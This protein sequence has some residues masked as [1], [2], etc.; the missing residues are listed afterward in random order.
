MIMDEQPTPE[1]QTSPAEQAVPARQSKFTQKRRQVFCRCVR[2]GLDFTHA[3]HVAGIS[4][5]LFERTRREDPAFVRQVERAVAA[6][7]EDNRRIVEQTKKSKFPAL[8]FRAATWDLEHH[9]ST[10]PWYGKRDHV[11]TAGAALVSVG[12]FLPQKGADPKLVE[13]ITPPPPKALI[14]EGSQDDGDTD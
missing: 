10:A 3:A 1:Q 8:R 14:T 5:A 7:V 9:P 11:Q 4:R 6:L 12:I 2:K 13:V